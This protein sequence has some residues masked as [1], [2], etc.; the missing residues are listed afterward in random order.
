MIQDEDVYVEVGYDGD[1]G[2]A[3]KVHTGA[4]TSLET[5]V[6]RDRDFGGA[7]IIKKY[8]ILVVDGRVARCSKFAGAVE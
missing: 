7:H 8:L 2:Y 6:R 5:H 4:S 1:Q 3:P